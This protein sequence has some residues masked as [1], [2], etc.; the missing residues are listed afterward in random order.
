MTEIIRPEVI[1]IQYGLKYNSDFSCQTN[2][3][4]NALRIAM[5]EPEETPFPIIY[6]M[7][8]S[9]KSND[10]HAYLIWKNS[11]LNGEVT[12]NNQEYPD[13]SLEEIYSKGKDSTK[14][15]LSVAIIAF[16][17]DKANLQK[18]S[19]IGRA[20]RHFRL[21]IEETFSGVQHSEAVASLI[22]GYKQVTGL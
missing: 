17:G 9:N 18:N 6:Q 15:I 4:L 21:A 13:F 16:F 20:L 1:I 14:E 3:L 7:P 19:N 11:V 12:A 8:M 22:W 10:V 5:L 2:A